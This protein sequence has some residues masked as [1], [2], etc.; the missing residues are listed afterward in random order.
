M[1]TRWTGPYVIAAYVGKGRYRLLD[2]QSVNPLK[3]AINS[4]WL[5]KYVKRSAKEK[6]NE[7]TVHE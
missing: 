4:S 2:E 7:G 3:Q 5:K 6:G 1:D